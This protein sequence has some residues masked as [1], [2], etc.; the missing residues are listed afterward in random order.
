MAITKTK[1]VLSLI[2]VTLIIATLYFLFMYTDFLF[3][4]LKQIQN[5]KQLETTIFKESLSLIPDQDTLH[6]ATRSFLICG[7]DAFL[8]NS[9]VTL[10]DRFQELK[11]SLIHI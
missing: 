6:L 10:S 8:N 4:S 9:D 5:Q 2:I 11:L 1:G 7:N 3:P